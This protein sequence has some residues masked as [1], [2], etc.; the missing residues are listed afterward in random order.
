[1]PY[2]SNFHSGSALDAGFESDDCEMSDSILLSPGYFHDDASTTISGRIP[3]PIHSSF[4]PHVRAERALRYTDPDFAD[5]EGVMDKM[6]R[7]RDLPSPISEGE[8]SP[9]L[10]RMA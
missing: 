3:T 7:A 6:R 2:S 5:D 4:A 10:S 1:M 8:M 9:A